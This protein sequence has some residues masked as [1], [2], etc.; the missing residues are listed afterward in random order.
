MTIAVKKLKKGDTVVVL[1]GKDKGRRGKVMR[2]LPRT[3]KIVVENL[4]MVKRHTKPTNTNPQGGI[5]QRPAPM[6][7][8]KV[9]VVCGKCNKPTRVAMKEKESGS[10]VRVCKKCGAGL[11]K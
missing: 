7:L 2:V 6:P 1:A 11:D 5:I 4:N 10:F 8:G 3:Q 9:M